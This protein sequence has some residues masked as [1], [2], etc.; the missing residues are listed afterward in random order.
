MAWA[1]YRM[2]SPCLGALAP[3]ARAFAPSAEQDLWGERLGQV[4][5]EGG[6]HAWI[7]AASLGESGA[8]A[9]LIAELRSL[10]EGARFQLTATTQAGRARLAS[11]GLPVS[12][13]PLDS[14]QATRQFF[15]GIQPQRL[16]LVETELWPQWL[17]RARAERVPVAVVS[18]R[19][20]E[21]SVRSYRRLGAGWRELIAGLDAVLCQSPEDARRW[22]E[23]GAR[24]E[25]TAAAGN[26]KDDS[27]PPC[28][29]AAARRGPPSGSIPSGRS[30]F[31]GASVPAR[32]GFSPGPG[33]RCR[34][35]CAS[36]GR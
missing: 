7:H 27:L 29:R 11:L 10:H 26:L 23:L 33:A 19:L 4:S 3:A 2:L 35:H 32:L 5:F 15:E 17:L 30:S 20:S 22:Q 9:P 24:P 21:R 14:P 13:A 36:A 25:R 12:L 1:A 16:I 34:S 18:A 6:C 28:P 8:V 31:W